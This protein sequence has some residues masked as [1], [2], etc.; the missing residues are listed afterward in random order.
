MPYTDNVGMFFVASMLL[1]FFTD[2]RY[3]MKIPIVLLL[4]YAGAWIKITALI[5]MIAMLIYLVLTIDYDKNYLSELKRKNSNYKRSKI[6]IVV[7]VCLVLFLFVALYSD[8]KYRI[9]YNNEARG[10]QFMFM[11]GQGYDNTGQVGGRDYV[12]KWTDITSKY[13]NRNERLDECFEQAVDWIKGRGII[14]NIKFYV[15]KINVAFNDGG[16]HNVQPYDHEN[17]DHSL[18]YHF[19]DNEGEYYSFV[20]EI[21]QILWDLVLIM[22]CAPILIFSKNKNIGLYLFFELSIMGIVLYLFLFEGRSKY[23]YMF[24]PLILTY[25]GVLMEQVFKGIE[26]ILEQA[27]NNSLELGD[28]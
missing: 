4:G 17:V 14:G 8:N 10:W 19:Y 6:I 26:F 20:V 9:D 21:R 11:V 16:F 23:L 15:K 18:I 12:E 1:A 7:L 24:L 2:M 5:P 25:A 27:K 22:L 3:E 13:I 28:K